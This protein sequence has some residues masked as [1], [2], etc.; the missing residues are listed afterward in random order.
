MLTVDTPDPYVKLIIKS[1]PEGR[2][3]TTVKDNNHA[4]VW[5]ETFT[6]F[7]NGGVENTMGKSYYNY[8]HYTTYIYIYNNC[9]VTHMK[10]FKS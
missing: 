3:Q 5:N 9:I 7:I 2:K 4:P 10:R 1:A 6:F 8:C